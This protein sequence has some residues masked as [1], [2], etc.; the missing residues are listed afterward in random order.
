M[1]LLYPEDVDQR[2][3]GPSCGRGGTGGREGGE[4]RQG[5]AS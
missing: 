1:G 2:L 5:A 4:E 3:D